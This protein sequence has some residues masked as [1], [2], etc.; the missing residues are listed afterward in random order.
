LPAP[1]ALFLAELA[2]VVVAGLWIGRAI[3]GRR[4][5]RRA[6]A[7][8]ATG[9]V[10]LPLGGQ[11]WRQAD[12]M[13]AARTGLKLPAGVPGHAKCFYDTGRELHLGIVRVIRD[14]VPADARIAMSGK[15]LDHACW[16]LAITP[17]FVVRPGATH[18]WALHIGTPS[19]E[20]ALRAEAERGRPE[21]RRTF[22]LFPGAA[23]LAR[24][25]S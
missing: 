3:G 9:L 15:P 10:A 24:T 16:S 17:R 6:V 14:V 25:A 23:T 13:V 11:L 5:E 1:Y 18:T 20:D 8:V 22:W 12:A 4:L 7:I 2:G 19:R 21:V